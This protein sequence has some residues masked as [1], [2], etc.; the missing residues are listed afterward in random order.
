MMYTIIRDSWQNQL[1][2]IGTV[3][4]II[5]DP[6][7]DMPTAAHQRMVVFRNKA[8]GNSL[9]FCKPENQFFVPDEYLFWQKPFRTMNYSKHC[10]RFVEMILVN[11]KGS[12]FNLLNWSQMTGHY[13]DT[14]VHPNTFHPYEKPVSLLERLIRI[15]TNPGDT[16]FDPFM[17]SGTT[18]VACQNTGR[19][20]IGT[21]IN[22][23]Y[24][25]IAKARL[26]ENE[27]K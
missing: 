6:D 9:F 1:H 3:D 22:K 15:Y 14:L 26:L 7:Y 25:D 24:F 20:F 23:K 2:N 21:E 13:N 27:R 17:G 5:T 8:R 10:G 4:A 11:R 19:I 12:T 16:I 18:G